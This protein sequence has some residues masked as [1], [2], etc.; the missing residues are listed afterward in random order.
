MHTIHTIA[1]AI[2]DNAYAGTTYHG[3]AVLI[4]DWNKLDNKA[5]RRLEDCADAKDIS[6]R[7]E[8]ELIADDNGKLHEIN[9]GYHGQTPTYFM[10]CVNECVWSVDECE[11]AGLREDYASLLIDN[12]HT[13]DQFGINF[14]TIGFTK[15]D[16]R[17][18]SGFHP[19]QN[20]TPDK[21]R[22]EIEAKHGPCEIIFSIDDVGQF[23][24]TFSAWFRAII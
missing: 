22:A 24:V 14:H 1:R 20:D 10:D 21:L 8:G 4:A 16:A 7:F 19:G 9:P 3:D 13:A 15:Y 6:L 5:M 17:C 2:D 23:D 11:D 12:P 18:E